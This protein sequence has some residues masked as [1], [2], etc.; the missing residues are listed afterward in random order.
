MPLRDAIDGGEQW[1]DRALCSL[2]GRTATMVNRDLRQVVEDLADYRARWGIESADPIG[3]VP[4]AAAQVAHLRAVVG[5]LPDLDR[6]GPPAQG[7][8]ELD[9]RPVAD[10][11]DVG[12][13]L[14]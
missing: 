8:E 14:G 11:S 4:R 6:S 12:I 3:G 7:I 1:V 13:G 2:V 5:D 9:H 10:A